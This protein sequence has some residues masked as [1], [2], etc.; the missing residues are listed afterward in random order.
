[1]ITYGGQQASSSFLQRY[2]GYV[3]QFGALLA[4]KLALD[5]KQGCHRSQNGSYGSAAVS[6]ISSQTDSR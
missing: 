3:E 2:T 1:M 5:A 6:V 4:A